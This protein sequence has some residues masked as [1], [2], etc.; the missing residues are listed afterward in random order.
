[1]PAAPL[2][3]AASLAPVPRWFAGEAKT[4]SKNSLV[5]WV[6][7]SA[8]IVAAY[9]LSSSLAM[10]AETGPITAHMDTF[11]IPQGANYFALSMKP[12]VA[13]PVVHA[14]ACQSRFLS[15]GR[16]TAFI[17]LASRPFHAPPSSQET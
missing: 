13:S 16:P 2:R 5:R 9:G 3:N 12:A 17:S 11:S 6:V 8:A 10:G 1:V 15:T 14:R 4:M 7:V